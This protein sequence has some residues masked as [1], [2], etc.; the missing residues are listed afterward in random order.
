MGLPSTDT[1][2]DSYCHSMWLSN[3]FFS[4]LAPFSFKIFLQ[5]KSFPS[6]F[7]SSFNLQHTENIWFNGD[8]RQ[9]E[10]TILSTLILQLVS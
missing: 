9:L 6:S 1:I 2:T 5:K 8:H 3:L 10:K 7:P 4:L